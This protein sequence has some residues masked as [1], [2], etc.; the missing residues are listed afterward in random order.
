MRSYPPL[1]IVKVFLVPGASGGAFPQPVV[2]ALRA[3]GRNAKT[4]NG[5]T[6]NIEVIRMM[7]TEKGKEL[8]F[9]SF[10][11]DGENFSFRNET[12]RHDC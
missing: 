1:S 8:E 2:V 6:N 5:S 9:L 7:E 12:N 11:V 10:C 3:A 4:V